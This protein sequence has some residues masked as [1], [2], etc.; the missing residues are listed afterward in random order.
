MTDFSWARQSF[1]TV[2]AFPVFP[3]TVFQIILKKNFV[4]EPCFYPGVVL[5]L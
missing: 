1:K 5:C 2:Q 3:R 4:D